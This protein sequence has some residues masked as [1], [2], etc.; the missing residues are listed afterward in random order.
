MNI[1]DAHIVNGVVTIKPRVSEHGTWIYS[2]P[3]T[4]AEAA[5]WRELEANR[6]SSMSTVPLATRRKSAPRLSEVK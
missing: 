5:E 4:K 1:N 2:R 6:L 3:A